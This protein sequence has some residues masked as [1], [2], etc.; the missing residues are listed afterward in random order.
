VPFYR[1]ASLAVLALVACDL[2]TGK[3]TWGS[4]ATLPWPG[5]TRRDNATHFCLT[6]RGSTLAELT[7]AVLAIRHM[8]PDIP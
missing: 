8:L 4:F 3:T 5:S 6:L 2:I 7:I 1:C